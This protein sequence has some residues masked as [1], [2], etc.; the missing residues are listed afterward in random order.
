LYAGYRCNARFGY[1]LQAEPIRAFD[2]DWS[3]PDSLLITSHVKGHL[4]TGRYQPYLLFGAGTMSA[5]LTD[6]GREDGFTTR[7]GGGLDYYATKHVV[8]SAGV[9]YVVPFFDVREM[10]YLSIGLGL[11]LR[12]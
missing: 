12:F 7:F 3:T 11:E 6:A 9:D 2:D 1:E 5:K 4:L 10:H 8:L